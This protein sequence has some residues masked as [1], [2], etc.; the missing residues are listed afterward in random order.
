MTGSWKKAS[1]FMKL[2]SQAHEGS[3]PLAPT[4]IG[5]RVYLMYHWTKAG[6]GVLASQEVGYSD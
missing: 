2:L 5:S 3:A 1:S 6:N 4:K